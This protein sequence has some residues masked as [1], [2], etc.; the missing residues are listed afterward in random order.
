MSFFEKLKSGIKNVQDRVTGDYGEVKI[1]VGESAFQPGDA[2]NVS[3]EL[4]AKADLKVTRILL[5]LEGKEETRV[6][7]QLPSGESVEEMVTAQKRLLVRSV[8][9]P[10]EPEPEPQPPGY[11]VTE[12]GINLQYHR[13]SVNLHDCSL[14][15]VCAV[16]APMGLGVSK[17]TRTAPSGGYPPQPG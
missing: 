16:D 11:S 17:Q 12:S 4:S 14:P 1:A 3:V 6:R 2:V 13:S 5:M 15:S 10:R 9:E 8:S 7:E